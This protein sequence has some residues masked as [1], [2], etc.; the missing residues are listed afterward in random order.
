MTYL[1]HHYNFLLLWHPEVIALVVLLTI[2]Y[3]EITGPLK[4]RVGLSAM[5]V[6]TRQWIFWILA[7]AAL[8]LAMGTPIS[9]LADRY[10]YLFHVI[11][12]SI[13]SVVVPP[14][15]WASI[16]QPLI[17][18]FIAR[19]AIKGLFRFWGNP[20]VAML[21]FNVLSW[22]WQYPP[23]LDATLSLSLLFTLGNYLMLVAALFLWWPL[24][25]P[26][27]PAGLRAGFLHL[28]V[29]PRDRAISPEAQML[30]VFFNM[31]L[32]IP[33]IV[34]VADATR[35]IYRFYLHAPH[36][37]GIG[38]LADQQLGIILMGI[39]M[40]VAYGIAFAAAFRF[41]DMSSWYA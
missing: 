32:M 12:L 34:F 25:G 13:L 37:F 17:R 41:Y 20:L 33:P 40:F 38:P 10:L 28:V 2:L 35:P 4:E 26:A 23:I 24:M 8:Y 31:D 6:T 5:Q 22:A 15:V 39:I 7:M 9:I 16:P 3:V 18:A 27:S 30:Y 14:L 1:E 29:P 19:P 21:V 11:Q 36:I